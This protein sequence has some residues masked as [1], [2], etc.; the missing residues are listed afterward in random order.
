MTRRKRTKKR[1]YIEESKEENY[2]IKT[3]RKIKKEGERK[4]GRIKDQK[5]HK[6][7]GKEMG[8]KRT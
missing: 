3:D 7:R 4:V 5:E 1:N 2:R 6:R 8:Q